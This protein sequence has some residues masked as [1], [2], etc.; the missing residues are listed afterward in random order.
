MLLWNWAPIIKSYTQHSITH[1]IWNAA[2]WRWKKEFDILYGLTVFATRFICLYCQIGKCNALGCLYKQ[3]GLRKYC[4]ILSN[5]C[6][7]IFLQTKWKSYAQIDFFD[8]LMH[9]DSWSPPFEKK[10]KKISM[11]SSYIIAPAAVLLAVNFSGSCLRIILPS[12]CQ[13]SFPRGSLEEP[14]TSLLHHLDDWTF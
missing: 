8:K 10:I 3:V 4:H 13:L 6:L 9:S 1:L 12:W 5:R 2:I 11:Y 7:D 14:D